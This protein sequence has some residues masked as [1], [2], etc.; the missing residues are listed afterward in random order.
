MAL[1]MSNI[2]D[3]DGSVILASCPFYAANP[4]CVNT[5]ALFA[6]FVQEIDGEVIVDHEHGQC[7]L[8]ISKYGQPQ[9]LSALDTDTEDKI[10][11]RKG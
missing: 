11:Y 10:R 5:C 8:G 1:M 9:L 6:P 3:E 2:Y 4:L 7:S